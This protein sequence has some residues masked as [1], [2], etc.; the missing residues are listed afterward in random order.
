[1]DSYSRWL[2]GLDFF[3]TPHDDDPDG[4]AN[5]ADSDGSDKDE[6]DMDPILPHDNTVTRGT[7]E[8]FQ[9]QVKSMQV[10]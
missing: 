2:H 10:W 6:D 4:T 8:F 5:A 7:L 9:E 3:H 1:M